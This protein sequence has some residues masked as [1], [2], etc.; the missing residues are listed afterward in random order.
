MTT[1]PLD[2]PD[3]PSPPRAGRRRFVLTCLLSFLSPLPPSSLLSPLSSLSA[4]RSPLSALRSPLSALRSPLS[5]LLSLLSLL[6][7]QIGPTGE[8]GAA[9]AAGDFAALYELTRPIAKACIITIAHRMHH[10]HH[11]VHASVIHRQF[12]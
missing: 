12:D 8:L 6:S 11:R 10:H 1:A 5:S 3:P 9:V 4:L 7:P 2:R